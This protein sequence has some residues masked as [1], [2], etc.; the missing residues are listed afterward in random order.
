M[1][2]RSFSFVHHSLGS[3]SGLVKYD[4]KVVQFRSIPYAT[5]PARFEHSVL[6]DNL[7]GTDRDFTKTG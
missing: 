7:D 5:I 1:G 2:Y 3:L 4:N 6:L